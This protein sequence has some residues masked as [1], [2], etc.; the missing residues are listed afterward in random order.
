M[1]LYPVHGQDIYL[2]TPPFFEEVSIRN[3]VTGKTATIRNKNFDPTH[4]NIY[5]QSAK[6]D[7]KIYEKNYIKHDFFAKGGVLELELGEK[8][9]VWGTRVKD[10]PPSLPVDDPLVPEVE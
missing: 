3:A 8:E 6:W 10:L 5:I 7:G 1:G 9:S 2:I 4:K